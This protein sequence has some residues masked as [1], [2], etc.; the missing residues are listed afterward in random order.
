MNLMEHL[1]K[2]TYKTFIYY[3]TYDEIDAEIKYYFY[4]DVLIYFKSESEFKK[5]IDRK[6][7]IK[8]LERL[9]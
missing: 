3:W 6:I 9:L 5:Y 8:K 1:P 4:E 7:R 2:G